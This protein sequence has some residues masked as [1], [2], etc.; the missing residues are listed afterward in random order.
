MKVVRKLRRK[1]NTTR[2]TS[3]TEM[4][5][6]RSTS[7]TDARMVTVWSIATVRSMAARNGR[8]QL[9]ES[10]ADAVHRSE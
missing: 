7:L 9:R 2:M 10:G 5:S 8:L 4:T 6:V 1:K 3:S